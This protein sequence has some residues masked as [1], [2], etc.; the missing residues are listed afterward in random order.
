MMFH[1]DGY[2]W[3]VVP[4]TAIEGGPIQ[5]SITLTEVYGFD[6][7]DVWAVGSK[8]SQDPVSLELE[9]SSLIIHFDGIRWSEVNHPHQSSLT[10]IAG[11]APTDI[12]ITSDTGG[13]LH[14]DG[15]EWQVNQVD[16]KLF[17]T[18]ITENVFDGSFTVG[19][20]SDY[21]TPLD[22]AGVFLYRYDS[23]HWVLIDSVSRIPGASAPHFGSRLW[24]DGHVIYSLGPNV[25]IYDN[26]SW[27]KLV[28]GS[29]GNMGKSSENNIFAV[30]GPILH[31]NGLNWYEYTNASTLGVQWY[32]CYTNGDE[33]FVVG[34][35]NYQTIILHGK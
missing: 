29:V 22:S 5:G 12:W 13:T 16:R 4:L 14:F 28:D 27:R 11:L 30:G 23:S 6:S 7:S 19:V 8:F 24:S 1:Y 34:N 20:R 9:Y 32:D 21:T 18:S 35:D 10:S 15:V 25:F 17:M 33:V 26:N 3:R 2:S 31:Y